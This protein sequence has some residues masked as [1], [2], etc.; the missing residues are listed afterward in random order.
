MRLLHPT[1]LRARV[2]TGV[3]AI[4]VLVVLYLL[5]S[6]Y[7]AN[8]ALTADRNPIEERPEDY[9]LVYEDVAFSPRGDSAI[10]LRGWWMPAEDAKGVIVR[11]HGLDSNRGASLGLTDALVKAGYSVFAFDLRG[12][13]ESDPAQMGASIRERDDLRGALDHVLQERGAQ[14]GRVLVYGESYGG[15]VALSTSLDEPAV[16]GVFTDSAFASLSDLVVQEVASRTILP[17][18][19]A[20]TLRPGI[21]LAARTL[22]GLDINEARPVDAVARYAY[23]LGMVHCRAD[24]RIALSHLARIRSQVQWPPHMTIYERCSHSMG[25][26]EYPDHYEAFLLDYFDLRLGL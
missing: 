25:W 3:A 23:P 20:A 24:E 4:A 22:K 16:A 14:P 26:E 15:A 9:G 18:W 12:H 6:L 2:L 19:G 1:T 8:N 13:G 21:L 10:T 17:E 7:I 11:V 5:A